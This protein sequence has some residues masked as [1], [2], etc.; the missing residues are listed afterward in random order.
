MSSEIAQAPT[1]DIPLSSAIAD[2]LGLPLNTHLEP[3]VSN[4]YDSTSSTEKPALDSTYDSPIP[5][6]TSNP[7]P[8]EPIDSTLG[9]EDEIASSSAAIPGTQ[10]KPAEGGLVPNVPIRSSSTA[11]TQTPG[12]TPMSEQ[13]AGDPISLSK[14]GSKGSIRQKSQVGGIVEKNPVEKEKASPLTA[15]DPEKLGREEQATKKTKPK[16]R[17]GLLSFLNCCSA[18]ENANTVDG[19]DQ[20]V[21]AKKAKVL[22][23]K[24]GRQPTPVVKANAS[25][26]ESSTG[27]SKEVVEESIGGPEYSE[28]K[29]A[30][31]PTMITRSS[32]DKVPAE[33]PVAQAPP[34]PAT[35]ETT[36]PPAATETRDSPLPPLPASNVSSPPEASTGQSMD[37][38][39]VIAVTAPPQ[40]IEPDQSVAEQGTTIN[41]RT[42][43]QEQADS[44]IAM[45]D[46]PP[47]A[48]AA[49]EPSTTTRDPTQAQVNL[50]P[51]PPRNGQ[52]TTTSG[53]SAV[54]PS[55]KQRWLLPPLQPHFK[56][57]KCLVLDLDETLVHSSFKILHQADFTIPVEIEGQ[58]HNVYVIKR[59]GVDQFMKRVGELYE[60]VVFTASV[61]KYGDPLL[62]Q[63]DIHKV[64]HHRLFRES[65]YNHQGNYVKDLSQVGRDL[66]ETIII[67]NSPTSYIFHPQHAVPISS[68]FSDAH[69]NELLDLIPV[70]EDLAGSQVRDV[71]LVLDV[72]L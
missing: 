16:K 52:D 67:D 56:G 62:D 4:A 6:S 69:D 2:D 3:P 21:P 46:A 17:G 27:E 24:P 45:V 71:S 19:G 70:L 38:T 5:S 9:G 68:W 60:V 33:R 61:S 10:E 42:T 59:P 43:Q 12:I 22:Q 58:F 13:S 14:K 7:L 39:P 57:R 11:K 47:L 1:E 72:S 30:A 32:K 18:P 65:C 40:L 29:P 23:Q 28:L 20:A 51:P 36:E 37:A 25:A 53:S 26:G 31:K 34:V 64:V 63:L 49:E 55:D 8:P 50:P 15:T 44:D 35:A 41:D 54:T 48:A 66:R